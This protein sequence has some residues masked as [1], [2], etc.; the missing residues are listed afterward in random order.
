LNAPDDLQIAPLAG[1]DGEPAFNEPWQAQVLALAFALAKVGVFTPVE[2]SDALGTE[3]RRAADQGETDDQTTYYAAAL[4]ALEG[5]IVAD[6]RVTTD[7][8][9]ER[10]EQWRHAYLNTPHGNPVNLSA[11]S[12]I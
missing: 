11:G 9:A 7:G 4:A 6:G 1:R 12:C 5:L 2:W 8:L 10:I 3:L